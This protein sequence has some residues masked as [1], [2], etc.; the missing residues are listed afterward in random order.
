MQAMSALNCFGLMRSIK[1]INPPRAL[2]PP[3]ERGTSHALSSCRLLVSYPSWLRPSLSPGLH[4][5]LHVK[6]EGLVFPEFPNQATV[7][8]YLDNQIQSAN[9]K[10]PGDLKIMRNRLLLTLLKKC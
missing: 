9:L 3:S 5:T 4:L 7:T 10:I 1:A 2:F 8:C 6:P